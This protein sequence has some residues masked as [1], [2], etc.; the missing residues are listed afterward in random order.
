MLILRAEHS[1]KESYTL[2]DSVAR[3]IFLRLLNENIADCRIPFVIEGREYIAGGGQD[4]CGC[5]VHVH[6]PGFFSRVLAFGNL[7]MGEAF[8]DRDFEIVGGSLPEFLTV[9]LRNRVDQKLGRDPRRLL[10]LIAI[11]GVS[12]LRRKGRK[13]CS[14]RE[15]GNDLLEAFLDSTLTFSSGYA[16]REDDDL[17]QLQR[18]KLERICRKLQ[19]TPGDRLLD[20]GCGCGSLLIFAAQNCGASGLGI[21]LS[22]EQ[23][24]RGRREIAAQGLADRVQILARDYRSLEGRYTKVSSIGMMAHLP[25]SDYDGF[26]RTIARV[27]EPGGLGILHTI[28]CNSAR[29]RHDAFIQEYIFPGSNQPRL[30]EIA[31]HLGENGFFVLDV[32]N[33]VRHC[34]YTFLKWLANFQ[35]NAPS[36]VA[37]YGEKFLRAWEYYL[38]C[39]AAAAVASDS[40]LY[41]VL[42]TNDRAVN[43]PLCR[44]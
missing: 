22:A 27:L 35:K 42:F 3:E 25:R 26:F 1:E 37:H 19:L 28:G 29:N 20:I 23:C 15:A 12:R 18:N 21:T 13:V 38:S 9:L 4:V 6:N 16:V 31:G 43:I 30:S 34:K 41:Q 2:P 8:V 11:R 5:S 40:A 39:G 17:E 33:D 24:E 7:G 10:K 36:L 14:H 44:V 32:E